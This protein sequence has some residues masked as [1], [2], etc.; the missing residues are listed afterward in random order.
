MQQSMKF[1]GAAFQRN[2]C[3][4]RKTTTILFGAFLAAVL[5]TVVFAPSALAQLRAKPQASNQLQAVQISATICGSFDYT[6]EGTGAWVGYA[7][8]TFGDKPA[9]VATFADRNT[10]FNQRQNGSIY[11][12]ETISLKF[13]DGSGTFDI[14]ASFQ[15]TPGATPHLYNLHE[16]GAISNGTGEYARLS[17]YVTVQGPFLLPDPTITAGAPSWIAQVHGA[18]FGL[19]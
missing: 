10:S 11:G 9:K 19:N 18:V 15:G 1:T 17:G 4:D 5:A 13:A 7:L 16:A 8:V 3:R 12:T 14:F 2:T 6:F